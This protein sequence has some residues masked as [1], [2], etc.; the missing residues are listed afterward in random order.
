M[1]GGDKLLETMS[2]ERPATDSRARVQSTHGLNAMTKPM[3]DEHPKDLDRG[4][5]AP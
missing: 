3:F 2:L 1:W 4:A 5:A